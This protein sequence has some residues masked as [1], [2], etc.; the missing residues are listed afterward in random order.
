MNLKNITNV[1]Q[2]APIFAK[3]INKGVKWLDN[4]YHGREDW[5][6]KI[7]I[8]KLDMADRYVCMCGQVFGDYFSVFNS[9]TEDQIDLGF[10]IEEEVSDKFEHAF[11]L[12]TYMW[13][14]KLTELNEKKFKNGFKI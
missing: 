10:Q 3:R 13:F 8:S 6:A 7:N 1:N 9:F 14:I 12:L 5:M 2:L 4:R 11:D